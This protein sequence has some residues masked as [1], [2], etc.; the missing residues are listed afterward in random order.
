M[1]RPLG[2]PWRLS[3]VQEVGVLWALGFLGIILSFLL[4][5]GSSIPKLVATL[6]FLYLPVVA[7]RWRDE[8]YRDYGLTLR[9]WRQ[10]TRLFLLMCLI[11]GPLFFLGFYLWVEVLP[12]LPPE[13]KRLLSPHRGTAHFTPQLPP[14]FG[15]WVIDQLFVVALPEE[16]F[17]RGY[18]QSRLRD[19]WPQG[20]K[21][22]GARLGPAFWVTAALFA[23]G[24]LAIFQAWRLAVFFPAL[25]FGWMRERT[26]TVLGAALFHAAC[27]LYIRFLEVS[28]FGA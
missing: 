10:D 15:E 21:V 4:F 17:Y 20:R 12:H 19:A 26:G 6:G 5:G 25:L 8:D 23:L 14:R 13:L 18:M 28:F 3:A 1:S 27:N 7:M 16:F 2:A 22:L 11:V 9:A 24:H